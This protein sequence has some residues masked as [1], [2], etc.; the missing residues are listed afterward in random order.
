MRI[1]MDRLTSEVLQSL[2]EE[3]VNRE[4]TDYG[5]AT[6]SLEEKCAS[7]RRQLEAGEASIVFDPDTETCNI[8]T[9]EALAK[10]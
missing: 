7:V 9:E 2:I 3:F 10:A 1:P 8:L 6:H 4:G 5:L